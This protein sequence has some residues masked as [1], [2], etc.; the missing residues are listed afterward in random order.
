M[1][2]TYLIGA[3]IY[4]ITGPAAELGMMGYGRAGQTTRGIHTRLRSR[5]F[6]FAEVKN[7]ERRVVFVSADLG[8][9]FQGVKQAVI[10]R[11]QARFGEG[12][13]SPANVL[14]SATHTHSGP[15]GFSHYT[16]YNLTTLGFSARNFEA[17]V[18]GI[19]ESITRAHHN[20]VEGT[21]RTAA[22][23][24]FG[25]SINRSPSAYLRNPEAE[26][27][28]FPH[29]TDKRMTLL[30]CDGLD[31]EPLGEINWFAVHG[32]SLH[33][34]NRLISG[35]N[36]GY[37]SY[38][39]ER[40]LDTDYAAS[41]T[42]V[43]AFAQSNEG[44]VSPNVL[45]DIDG[46]GCLE[47]HGVDD[48]E[49]TH[50]SGRAQF[51]HA[52]LLYEEADAE[53]HGPIDFRH[54]FVNFSD[55]EFPLETGELVRTR[56]AAIGISMIAGADDGPGYGRQGVSCEHP[57]LD[58]LYPARHAEKPVLF[59]MGHAKP[60]PWTPEVL[61]VQILRVGSLAIIGLPGEFTTMS[62]RRIRNVVASALAG[63]GVDHVV[64]A[65]LSNAY[66]GYVTT[67]EEYAAQQY[68]GAST[69]FGPWTL[70]AYQHQVGR[71]AQALATGE[72]VP[73]GPT[74]R[75]LCAAQHCFKPGVVFD[76]APP[77][78]HFGE[79]AKDSKP[80]YH[81][82]EHVDVSFWGAHL[83]NDL[84]TQGSFLEVQR[85]TTDGWLPVA[86]DWDPETQIVWERVG[87]AASRVRVHWEIPRYAAPGTYRIAHFGKA[88]R[89][90]RKL[91]PYTGLSSPFRITSARA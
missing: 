8:M 91:R 86:R 79:V 82:G 77:F 87:L 76:A 27:A 42:F 50:I 64:I 66:S 24:L 55:L 75:N 37:A 7:P 53:L 22:S 68:E 16:L 48:V 25:V 59:A 51:E 78:K 43:A 44:D 31:G 88:K 60:Y 23:D 46:D 83:A 5:A 40:A 11:L 4:D 32:T 63:S 28:R 41:R 70:A 20:L 14:L 13:Y 10:Q 12:L 6:V 38:L 35:D 3:G 84:M 62:G 61:P 57:L 81:P 90:D 52:A 58:A 69:H 15:G 34:T 45:G 33:N 49:S 21:L 71:L 26:R 9:I 18:E 67:R 65:G 80:S 73:A 39:F 29:D 72:P 89:I 85:H 30:R 2:N 17:I 47:G 19:V 56:R 1:K 36:K 54:A 74:P